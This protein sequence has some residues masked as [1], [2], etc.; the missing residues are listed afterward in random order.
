MANA[1]RDSNYVPTKIGILN[2]TGTDIVRL[3]VKPTN[4]ALK[5]S[6]GTTGS[7]RGPTNAL[8]DDNDVPTML[9]V[10]SS[11]FR[12]VTTIYVDVNGALMIQST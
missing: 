5:V 9:G 1:S 3:T 6:D 8:R 10:S 7:N 4:H 2:T 11:D 12:T